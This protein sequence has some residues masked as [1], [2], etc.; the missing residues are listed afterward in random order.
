MTLCI[1]GAVVVVCVIVLLVLYGQFRRSPQYSLLQL[2]KAF[3][4]HDMLTVERYADIDGVFEGAIDELTSEFMSRNAPTN[5]WE[6]LGQQLGQTFITAMKP[7]LLR[8]AKNSLRRLVE[9]GPALSTDSTAGQA[10]TNLTMPLQTARK[11]SVRFKGILKVVRSGKVADIT[12]GFHYTRYDTTIPL[13]LRMR[14]MGGYWQVA[15][16][17]DI[18]GYLQKLDRMEMARIDSLNEPIV[19]EIRRHIEL[20]DLRKTEWYDDYWGY[21]GTVQFS[22]TFRNVGNCDINSAMGALFVRSPSWSIDD[23]IY[24]WLDDPLAPGGTVTKTRR[25]D[26]NMFS[27]G[28]K[29]LFS[30]PLTALDTQLVYGS[31]NLGDGTVLKPHF[32]GEDE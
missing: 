27:T 16:I 15:E 11:D 22:L 18:V 23:T 17:K 7:N 9:G 10:V 19:D 24:F 25:M 1:V 28:D 4:Q 32:K 8:E 26:A 2:Q 30:A 31:V 29:A 14:D 20:T 21:S 5:G 13:L 6:A 12:L 3:R